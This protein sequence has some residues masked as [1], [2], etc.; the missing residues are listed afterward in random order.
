MP[1][2]GHANGAGDAWAETTEWNSERIALGGGMFLRF[3]PRKVWA[4]F[5]PG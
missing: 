1:D 2:S 5:R 3:S 4:G